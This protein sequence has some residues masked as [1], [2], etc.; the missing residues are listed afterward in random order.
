MWHYSLLFFNFQY[1]LESQLDSQHGGYESLGTFAYDKVHK[2]TSC[3]NH[4]AISHWAQ[5]TG[6]KYRGTLMNLDNKG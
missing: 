4:L 2:S 5:V 3:I 1:L 6:R